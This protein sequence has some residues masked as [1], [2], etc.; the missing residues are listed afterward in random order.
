[1]FYTVSTMKK[2]LI[3]T[4]VILG[5]EVLSP[6]AGFSATLDAYF[7]LQKGASWEYDTTEKGKKSS[8][9]MKVTVTEPW[10][11]DGAS[12]MVMVQKD[13]R[14]TMRQFLL[15]KDDGVYLKKLGLS[16]SYTPEIFTRFNPPMPAV[17]YPFEPGKKVHWE[18]RLKVATINKPI[19]F[20]GEVIG[21]EDVD[22]P[23]GHY[24]CIKLHFHE[25][26]GDDV[27]D[28]DVWYAENVG[29]IKYNGGQYIKVL[30]S[31]KSSASSTE[32]TEPTK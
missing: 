26:R 13:K 29:Q 17:I 9:L 7:P 8:F 28:E 27:V 15:S 5:L 20:D 16:K 3:F 6:R 25:K 18:G 32:K 2:L 31:Y 11:E 19:I 30:K 12:G 4:V 21:W 23:A 14:G 10:D 1:M 24:H 22:V